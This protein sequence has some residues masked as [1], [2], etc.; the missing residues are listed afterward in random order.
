[1]K[2]LIFACTMPPLGAFEQCH[3]PPF[4]VLLCF[5]PLLVFGLF[6]MEFVT[7]QFIVLAKKLRKETRKA[8]TL[9]RIDLHDI[10]DAIQ[11]HR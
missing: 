8:L 5:R 11:S 4:K 6:H 10:K 1:M 9:L 7:R 3:H 2:H